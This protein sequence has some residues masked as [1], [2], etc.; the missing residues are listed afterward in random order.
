MKHLANIDWVWF[1]SGNWPLLDALPLRDET[2]EKEF[3]QT[4]GIH[5]EV[6]LDFC[7]NGII[8]C[9]HS[10]EEYDRLG[11]FFLKRFKEDPTFI[12]KSLEEY[13]SRTARDV[14]ALQEIS[15]LPFASLANKELAAVFRK[16]RGHFGYNAAMDHY[17]WYIEKFFIPELQKYVHTKLIELGKPQELASYMAALVTPR[18]PSRIFNERKELFQIVDSIRNDI[19][20][21]AAFLS[22]EGVEHSQLK[23]RIRGHLEKHGYLPVL[24]NNPPTSEED[25]IE[26]LR[27]FI[28]SEE[29]FKVE[30]KRIG[31]NFDTNILRKKEE[32]LKE[33]IT[34]QNIM[35]LI[36]GLEETA[37][38]RTE[39]NAVMSQSSHLIIPFYNEVA[40]RIGVTYTELK[41]L[42]PEEILDFLEGNK[43]APR[44]LIEQRLELTAHIVHRG[45][46]A[47]LTGAEAQLVKTIVD[48]QLLG[49]EKTDIFIGV[50]AS[51]GKAVGKVKVARSSKDALAIEKGD[52]LI[53]PATSA[54]FV[55]AMRRAAAIVT[56]F[57][58]ITSH[59]AV[60]SREFG[61]PCIVGVKGI[62]SALNDGDRVEVDAEKGTIRKL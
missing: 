27:Q 48:S 52:I 21:T 26:E 11:A 34:P 13:P 9:Y 24:V 59:A 7:Q 46:R 58:G 62:T 18:K 33:L 44:S 49:G 42:L 2:F 3:H 39:D 54:D 23:E 51:M 35:H 40:R 12:K 4:A 19:E 29:T 43:E 8:T 47:T 6:S 17:T 20:L 57:G 15:R 30:S 60:V 1:W 50:A 36:E 25:V 31:D 32:I 45:N 41:E 22:S 61:V 5:P 37:F 10:Q 38:T 28:R 55:L 56:E 16:V 53:A 14:A